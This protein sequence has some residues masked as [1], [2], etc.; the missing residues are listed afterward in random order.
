MFDS[1]VN[2]LQEYSDQL[3][4]IQD[5]LREDPTNAEFLQLK[6]DLIELIS[7]TTHQEQLKSVSSGLLVLGASTGAP[8][9]GSNEQEEKEPVRKG[10]EVIYSPSENL[11]H[12][13]L[14]NEKKKSEETTFPLS[15][16]STSAKGNVAEPTEVAT[17]ATSKRKEPANISETFQ[18]PS[19]LIPLESDTAAEQN[20]KR[21]TIK[22]LKRQH[23]EK[24][25]EL[26]AA[27]KQQSWQQFSSKAMKK[28]KGK[29]DSIWRTSETRGVGVVGT[30]VQKQE[31][32][33]S[34]KRF[35][36]GG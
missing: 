4:Q 31:A 24:V 6:K 16:K 26:H 14:T 22:A 1:D 35:K 27:S 5:L 7:L 8:H 29:T 25:K 20:R 17:T 18:V 28:I 23:K 34:S 12:D 2:I 13:D 33:H 15:K 19:H 21:R 3:N 30:H 9:S 11:D 36:S 10:I 32:A